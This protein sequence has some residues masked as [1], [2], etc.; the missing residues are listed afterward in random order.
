[1]A[2]AKTHYTA[3]MSNS[4]KFISGLSF[5]LIT[6]IIL[7]I[8]VVEIFIFLPS[9]AN[10]RQSWLND[11]LSVATVA[12]RVLDFAPKEI[13]LSEGLADKLLESAQAIAIAYKIEGQSQLIKHSKM[14]MPKSSITADL[15]NKNKINQILGALDNLFF[16]SNRVIRIVGQVPN[17]ENITIEILLNEAPLKKDMLD[18]S[19]SLIFFSLIIAALTAF[20]IY[21][22]I[23]K[24]LIV[25]IKRIIDNLIAFRKAPENATLILK[26]SKARDEIGMVETELSAL[27]NDLFSQ[28]SKRRHLADLGLAVAKINHDLRNMLTSV[29]LLSDQVANLDDPEAQRLAPKLVHSLDK[30]IG[31]AQSVLEHGR[32]KSSAPKPQPVDLQALVN[33][34]ALDAKISN[35]PNIK[36]VNQVPNSITLNL[37]P[38]Q[39]ARVIINLL[40]NSREALESSGTRT[41]KPSIKVTFK[42]KR[43]KGLAI[44]VSDNGPGLPPRAKDNLFVAFE[45][46]TKSGGTGLGLAIARE[47]V[48]AHGGTLEYIE[49]K[50]GANFAIYLPNS[51]YLE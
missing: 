4:G 1:M 9:I 6:T 24:S 51:V 28:L 7:V 19:K 5:K 16:G 44:I 35:H 48:E 43:D 46:S 22:F 12:M 45:G 21:L 49:S 39:M 41:K 8:L 15:R 10:F 17:D 20:A 34:C 36:F 2:K 14:T 3:Y 11:K 23:N 31:F 32:Q 29:Q 50:S 18:Y 37:D 33:E 26:P 30:A 27:E 38:D 42:N 47:I 25:P 40:N 13:D